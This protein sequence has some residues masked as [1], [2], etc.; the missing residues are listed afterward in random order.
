MRVMRRVALALHIAGLTVGVFLSVGAAHSVL[1]NMPTD[2][3]HRIEQRVATAF[4]LALVTAAFCFVLVRR[5]FAVLAPLMLVTSY[6]L[7]SVVVAMYSN[8][9]AK[10]FA[11][12]APDELPALYANASL[13]IAGGF[14]IAVAAWI[15]TYRNSRFPLL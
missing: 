4:A 12:A 2:S 7:F 6:A 10:G 1:E 3:T 13:M 5:G 14:V 9:L 15:W 8:G 11:P